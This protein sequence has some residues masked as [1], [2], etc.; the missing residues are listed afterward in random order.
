MKR[1]DT[2]VM[3]GRRKRLVDTIKEKGIKDENVLKA[4]GKIPRHFFVMLGLEFQAYEDKSLSINDEQTISQPYTVA[5]QTELLEIKEG[6]KVLEIGTGSGYQSAVL[7][8]LG[9]EV[10]TVERIFNLYEKS[11][12]I[13]KKLNYNANTFYSDGYN[14]LPD[15]AP[16]DA[17]IITAAIP[18]TPVNL[19]NQ[20]KIGGKLVA[21]VGSQSDTQQMKRLIKINETRYEEQFHGLFAFVPMLKG[22]I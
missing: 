3:Q 17:I 19:L 12:K 18:N 9:A 22:K 6:D 16:F 20:L 21:P 8:E 2:Y 5:F 13:L 1:E 14:G 15:Y 10:Y 7:C 11:T 4:I